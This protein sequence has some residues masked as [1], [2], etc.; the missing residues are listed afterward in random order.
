MPDDLTDLVE[1]I[2]DL[3]TPDEQ[4][5]LLDGARTFIRNGL[6]QN[7]LD[8]AHFRILNLD[9][10]NL[11]I[12]NPPLSF[13]LVAHQWL[14]TYDSTT[15]LFTAAQPFT[16]DLGDFPPGSGHAGQFLTTDAGGVLSWATIAG[17]TPLP[18]GTSLGTFVNVKAAPYNAVGDGVTDDYP[19]VMAAITANPGRAIYFPKGTYYMGTG[20]LINSDGSPISA[21]LLGDGP[22]FSVIK[23]NPALLGPLLMFGTGIIA[24]L[25]FSGN[26][27]SVVQG[28]PVASPGIWIRNASRA[29]LRE[30]A[31]S[32]S[33]SH[34]IVIQGS[35]QS[36]LQSCRV[37][38]C[39]GYGV[40]VAQSPGT[41][42]LNCY[43]TGSLMSGAHCVNSPGSAFKG[44]QIKSCG[45]RAYGLGL[46]DSDNTVV[47]GNVIQQCLTGVNMVCS[48]VRS[49]LASYG[50]SLDDNVVTRN[51][52]GGIQISLAHGTRITG[53]SVIRNGGGG[54]DNATYSIEPGAI[55]APARPD[56]GYVVGD[57]LTVVGGTFTQAAKLLVT[58]VEVGGK[59]ALDG[60]MVIIPGAYSVFPANPVAVTGGT[61]TGAQ[62]VFS[63]SVISAP[64]TGYVVGQVLK[65]ASAGSFFNPVRGI[66]TSVDGAGGVTGFRITDG[67]GYYGTLPTSLTFTTESTTDGGITSNGS[68][69]A[70]FALLPCWGNRYSEFLNGFTAYGIQTYGPIITGVIDGN[71]IDSTQYGGTGVG[72]LI[73]D[74][75]VSPYIERATYLV[76]SSNIL[77]YN[78]LPIKG[79]TT[80]QPVDDDYTDFNV[81][82]DNNIF[83]P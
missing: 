33:P 2:E 48:S 53:N 42:V 32:D 7:D 13:P 81:I 75:T 67:G 19:G 60:V 50:Y 62:F 43:I 30:C 18:A 38:N 11:S 58:N 57:V 4:Q 46:Y 54:C 51:Y 17:V 39:G 83:Y 23:R 61:G 55:P 76:I 41:Q 47:E 15:R 12:A 1:D 44:N 80:G 22:T 36:V 21:T 5:V 78:S 49:G 73:A 29:L 82:D 72:I 59:I 45:H 35:L 26:V 70:G 16:A 8:A 66:V 71:V 9:L 79:Q 14:Q 28:N 40:W 31:V 27:A 74:S 6:M 20:N 65:D 10:S 25:G 77:V 37:E 63:S 64:G 69:G 56:S 24:G 3:V 68:A 34:G 52:F